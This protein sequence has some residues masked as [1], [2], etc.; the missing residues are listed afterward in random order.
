V[1][2]QAF[3]MYFLDKGEVQTPDLVGEG[4]ISAG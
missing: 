4:G 1:W 3:A 2:K